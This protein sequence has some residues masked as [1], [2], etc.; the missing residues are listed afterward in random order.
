VRSAIS[1]AITACLFWLLREAGLKIFPPPEA[2]AKL[3]LWGVLLFVPMW[4][5]CTFLRVYRWLHLLRAVEPAVPARRVIGISLIGFAALFAPMRMGELARP[6]LVARDK[7]VGFMQAAGTVVAERI[8][9]GVVLML[10]LALGLATAT[11]V[12]PLPD[13]V[14]ELQLPV[15]LI[16]TIA[17]SALV[18]FLSAFA[19]MAVFYFWRNLA[20]RLVFAVVG[21][22][23]K[24]LATF[25]TTQVERVSDS[26]SFLMSRKYGVAFLR[27][28]LGYW[29]LAVFGF[30]WLLRGAGAPA[31]L[32]QAAVTLGVLGLGTL[33][34]GPP[35]FFGTYQI[36]AYC[37]IAMFF[38]ELLT[39]SGVMF[40]F[41]SYATQ[42]VTGAI[43]L[44]IGMWILSNTRQAA[45]AAAA[46][47]SEQGLLSQSS[48]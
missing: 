36:G 44:L 34:P 14:G 6:L 24:P 26:L 4:V 16:P 9:D 39:T 20:R 23:S 29:G 3:E 43:S 42:L 35:G 2:W 22:V 48:R 31:S 37:G 40:T 8:V 41:I 28:T 10:I 25:I 11:R 19:A 5:G 27:D 30:W 21:L 15:R 18:F 12:D 46:Q 32:A 47:G 1:L 13:H 17:S 7:Q 33:I 45:T 38:P